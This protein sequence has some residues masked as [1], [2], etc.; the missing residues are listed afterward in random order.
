MS[1]NKIST[2]VIF[3]IVELILAVLTVLPTGTAGK[4]CLLGYNAL[5][6]FSPI[7]AIILLSMVGLHFYLYRKEQVSLV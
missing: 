1:D 6:S 3:M 5:C 4:D 7:S 2:H